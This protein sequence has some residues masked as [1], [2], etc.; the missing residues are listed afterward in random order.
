MGIR[1]GTFC[2]VTQYT[3]L[4]R[5]PMGAKNSNSAVKFQGNVF[6]PEAL[7][8]NVPIEVLE[9]TTQNKSEILKD[10]IYS[11][12]P[13][14]TWEEGRTAKLYD[15][16]AKK[17]LQV[18]NQ[19][20]KDYQK[21][22]P[23]D[24][25]Q[26]NKDLKKIIVYLFTNPVYNYAQN[27]IKTSEEKQVLNTMLNISPDEITAENFDMFLRFYIGARSRHAPCNQK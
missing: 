19:A 9:N 17:I 14:R 12:A 24:E 26:F 16:A 7:G 20:L 11:F 21:L 18:Q 4:A 13:I 6:S 2:P 15:E 8:F 25:Q 23:Y 22:T 5:K 3:G 27:A 10:L 1:M